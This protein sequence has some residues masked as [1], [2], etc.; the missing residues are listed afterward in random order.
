MQKKGTEE[1]V[2]SLDQ[3]AVQ[4]GVKGRLGGKTR[5]TGQVKRDPDPGHSFPAYG[6]FFNPFI[7]MTYI[8]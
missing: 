4:P 8:V 3:I 7:L 1:A 2:M 6:S 5:R